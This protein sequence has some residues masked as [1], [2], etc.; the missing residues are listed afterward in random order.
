MKFPQLGGDSYLSDCKRRDF[1]VE[2]DAWLNQ[3]ESGTHANEKQHSRDCDTS[4]KNSLHLAEKTKTL[5]LT[6][7]YPTEPFTAMKGWKGPQWSPSYTE[8]GKPLGRRK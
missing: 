1:A 5:V 4:N 6:Y 2:R 7:A 3:L 8:R